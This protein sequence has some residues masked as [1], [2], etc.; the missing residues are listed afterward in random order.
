MEQARHDSAG[1]TSEE[2]DES[3]AYGTMKINGTVR[4]QPTSSGQKMMEDLFDS[5][6]TG[7][8]VPVRNADTGTM[9]IS[10]GKSSTGTMLITDMDEDVDSGTMRRHNEGPSDRE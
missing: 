5:Y 4:R 10:E 6:A 1:E 2:D 7:T 9:V 3:A 8:M